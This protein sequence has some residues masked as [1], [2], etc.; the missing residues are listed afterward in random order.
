MEEYDPAAAPAP[1]RLPGAGSDRILA[2]LF[3][4]AG[5]VVLVENPRPDGK[6]P[7]ENDSFVYLSR[8][9]R[10]HDLPVPRVIAFDPAKGTY[11]MEDLGDDDLYGKVRVG[12][13]DGELRELYRE[14]ITLLSAM[15]VEGREGFDPART[16]SPPGY[17]RDLMLTWESGYFQRELLDNHLG[18]GNQP[19]DLR[20][21]FEKLADRTGRA[22]RDFFLHRDFQSM[23]LK[24]REGQLWIIDF[25]GA[26]LGPPQYDLAAF[27]FDPY[28]ELP[29]E[30]R[31]EM[32]ECYLV[33]LVGRTGIDHDRFLEDFPFVAA[34]RLMQA[35][36]AY[37][38][39]GHRK[40]KRDFLSF[41][42]AGLRLLA[43]VYRRLP[44]AEFPVLGRAIAEAQERAERAV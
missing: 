31:E 29:A 43:E 24:L 41:V 8:H 32:L 19:E 4:P 9:L 40:G 26:R 14:G 16:H 2:R 25:Q 23:N 42:P 11:L 13:T 38:F 34:H 39:L 37:A 35:L 20:S 33:D 7:D 36:G 5:T 30:L 22:G 1:H 44:A 17:D 28:V 27:L 21:E 6:H 18:L 10:G 12:V 15:Q 3:L